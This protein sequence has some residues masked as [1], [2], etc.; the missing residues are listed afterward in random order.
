MGGGE[1]KDIDGVEAKKM[2][3]CRCLLLQSMTLQI[4]NICSISRNYHKQNDLAD[5]TCIELDQILSP[6]APFRVVG[7]CLEII[8]K[9]LVVA[10]VLMVRRLNSD[11]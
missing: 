1:S 9:I 4:T 5:G 6:L 7:T 10:R 2:M 8:N 3:A 11:L